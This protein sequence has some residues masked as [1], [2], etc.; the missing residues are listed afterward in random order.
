MN[1]IINYF[2][3]LIKGEI[4]LF[5]SFW[6][7]FIFVSFII[8]LFFETDFIQSSYHHNSEDKYLDLFLYSIT[9][10][11]SIIIFVA[12][13]KSANRFQGKK[14]WAISSKII[15]TINLF[16]SLTVLND[17]IKF[18]FLEDYTIEKNI[19]EFKANL[20]I[21]VDV[22]TQ[23]IDIS[24]TDKIISYIYKLNQES[25]E[26]EFNDYKFKKQVQNSLCEDENTLSLLKK[27]YIL[28]YKYINKEEKE[29]IN[30]L[31]KK[32]N[33]GKNIY[34]IDI[35]KSILKAEGEM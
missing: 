22:N 32:D 6:I 33:C 17:T 29:L 14:I 4:P 1:E 30:I 21:F 2:K 35:L 7:W 27:D 15:V 19:N 9:L 20:P 18:Y 10:I 26:K 12:I 28:D 24:K 25:F 8:E 34:D 11:Y 23:L 13:Y 31:T 5:I 16:F 3:R